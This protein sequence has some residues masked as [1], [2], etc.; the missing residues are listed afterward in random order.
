MSD[1]RNVKFD[2]DPY[3][4][5]IKRQ[6][7]VNRLRAIPVCQ[8][9]GHGGICRLRMFHEGSCHFY[10]EGGVATAMNEPLDYITPNV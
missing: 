5:D 8:I 1:L 7:E 10:P 3:W 4:D 9:P 6:I 2:D